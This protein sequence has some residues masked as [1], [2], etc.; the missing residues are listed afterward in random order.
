MTR[1][2]VRD[3]DENIIGY[4]EPEEEYSYSSPADI[5]YTPEPPRPPLPDSFAYNFLGSIIPA[6]MFAGLVVG[7]VSAMSNSCG[8]CFLSGVLIVLVILIFIVCSV[9]EKRTA[10]RASQKIEEK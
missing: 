8:G 5:T 10:A 7:V 9:M 6:L 1:F 2:V 3:S 4:A